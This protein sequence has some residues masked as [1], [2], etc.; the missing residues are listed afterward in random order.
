MFLAPFHS[1]VDGLVRISAQQAS[2]FAKEV[3]GDFNP[4]HDP[5]SRR[6]CVPGDLLFS[7]V[8]AKCGVSR[9]MSFA[10]RDMV[11]DG[12]ALRFP[13]DGDGR[14]EVTD[15]AGKVFLDVER[16]GEVSCD[17]I[18]AEGLA[19]A[20]VAFSGH[21][22]PHILVP[23]MAEKGVML[24][25][26]R[27]LVIYESMSIALDRLDVAEPSLK[28]AGAVLD[29]N[30]KRGDISLRFDLKANGGVVGSGSKNLVLSGLR[31]YDEDVVRGLV[32]QYDGWKATYQPSVSA[33]K[34]ASPSMDL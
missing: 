5:D 19:R 11:G 34:R 10:F 4:I 7:L 29:V 12:V 31:E 1:E 23:L 25:P 24:N 33:R 18:L 2:R 14:I 9:E 15:E 6:F 3:A 27:P 21:N 30:G 13:R 20:Y 28:F 8:L 26:E 32:A 16:S 22:F 17:P